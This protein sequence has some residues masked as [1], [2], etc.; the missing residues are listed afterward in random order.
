MWRATLGSRG[1]AVGGGELAVGS[2]RRRDGGDLRRRSRRRTAARL[3]RRRSRARTVPARRCARSRAPRQGGRGRAG[4][5]GVAHEFRAMDDAVA[6]ARLADVGRSGGLAG[7]CGAVRGGCLARRPASTGGDDS[8]ARSGPGSIPTMCADADRHDRLPQRGRA[9]A[10]ARRVGG[11]ARARRAGASRWC[12][13]PPSRTDGARSRSRC[14]ARRRRDRGHRRCSPRCSTLR[15]AARGLQA[16]A[17][18]ATCWR[19][20]R[21]RR[22]CYL[23]ADSLIC[24]PLDDLEALAAEH[25][26]L[27]KART[28][29]RASRR[30]AAPERGG[31]ARLGAARRRHDRARRRRATTASCSNGGRARGAPAASADGGALPIGPRRDARRRGARDRRRRRSE[32]RSGISTGARSP[33]ARRAADRRR[34]AAPDAL[35]AL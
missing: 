11:R 14:C 35:P 25:G 13:T 33:P 1:A 12:S 31:P 32:R 8:A 21:A 30:R 5:S 18:R 10:G 23:D 28:A 20:R 24:G 27:V 3:S 2:I 6:G 9:C 16:A 19:A 22:C 34:A 15:G 7:A 17:P 26:V 4:S 29:R